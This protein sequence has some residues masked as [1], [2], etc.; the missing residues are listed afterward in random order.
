MKQFYILT[1]ALLSFNAL[2]MQIFIQTP[3]NGTITVEVEASDP[4]ENVKSKIQY[5][6]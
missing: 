2:G 6:N 5:W 3:N 4:I 1:L